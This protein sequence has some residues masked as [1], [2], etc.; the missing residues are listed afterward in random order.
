MA[1]VDQIGRTLCRAVRERVG[2]DGATF[3][4][5]A[6][7]RVRYIAEDAIAPL[8]AGQDF[9]MEACISGWTMVNAAPAIISDIYT[10]PRIPHAAY[11]PTFV[12]S[13]VMTPVMP[14]VALGAYWADQH[15]ATEAELEQLRAIANAGSRA[16][17][18]GSLAGKRVLIID[19]TAD[20]A[21][22]LG[23]VLENEGAVVSI[24]I[25]G[26]DGLRLAERSEFDLIISD[27]GMPI[28]DGYQFISRLRGIE[29]YRETPA[30]AVTGY[31]RSDDVE[32]ATAAGFSAHV[33]KPVDVKQLIALAR[34]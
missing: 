33:I 7:D 18:G 34:G 22:L 16:I 8:W 23:M 5:R 17:L 9:P 30:I 29:R 4:M 25:D 1:D 21:E 20:A 11:R 10:D 14:G 3:V 27:I 26:A 6:G 28:M 15:L 2:A 32:R 12:N 31:G 13:L 24:A 19:D